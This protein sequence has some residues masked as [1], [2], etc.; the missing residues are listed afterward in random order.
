MLAKLFPEELFIAALIAGCIGA[1]IGLVVRLAKGFDGG[2]AVGVMIESLF[3]TAIGGIAAFVFIRFLLL[4]GG[5]SKQAAVAV[6]ALFFIWPLIFDVLWAGIVTTFSSTTDPNAVLF[7][8]SELGALA[9]V[10]GALVGCFD[11]YRQ[12]HSWIGAGVPRFLSDVTWGL[13]LSFNGLLIHF[14]N[15]PRLFQVDGSTGLR[16]AVHDDDPRAGNHRY[17]RGFALVPTYAFSQ[18]SVISNLAG[19]A[20]PGTPGFNQIYAHEKTHVLQNRIF[21]PLFMVSYVVWLVVFGAI[22]LLVSLVAPT[23]KLSGGVELENAFAFWWGYKNNPWEVWAYRWNP[24]GR[25]ATVPGVPFGFNDVLLS[26]PVW[27]VVVFSFIIW[28][29][30]LLF[31]GWIVAD[32]WF[33]T[34]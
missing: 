31:L 32:V 22:G 30:S 26:W 1:I 7:G 16:R 9:F 13:A 10:T 6:G 19:V 4:L 17:S 5:D 15:L 27:V 14:V 28:P 11:G 23:R 18:G 34:A 12:I 24:D 3:T 25:M 2:R 33:G 20:A 8:P 29:L 21:G